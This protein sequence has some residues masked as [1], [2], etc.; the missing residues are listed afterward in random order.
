[1]SGNVCAFDDFAELAVVG[2]AVPPGDVAPDHASLFVV[3]GVIGSI[4][5]EVAQRLELGLDPVEP[6]RV[7]RHVGELDIVG[8]GPVADSLVFVGGQVGL[9][10]SNTIAIRTVGG[11]N[12]RRYRQNAKNSVRP[13][14]G[15]MCP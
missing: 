1:M 2:V 13:L 10:L 5:R 12:D 7:E 4:S 15:R 6:A 11:Y 14:R 9:K 3:S 8:C